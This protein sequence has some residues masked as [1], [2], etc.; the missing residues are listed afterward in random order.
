MTKEKKSAKYA[1]IYYEITPN[2]IQKANLNI[3]NIQT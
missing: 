1:D 3:F 2:I